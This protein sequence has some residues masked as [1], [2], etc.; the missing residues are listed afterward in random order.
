[1]ESLSSRQ[2]LAAD[3]GVAFPDVSGDGIL[4]PLDVLQVSNAV[5]QG[6]TATEQPRF[7]VNL[8]QVIDA[9]DVEATLAAL[10]AVLRERDLRNLETG[11]LPELDV[12]IMA[13][14]D[15]GDA[16]DPLMR[17]V[18]MLGIG[19][20]T[21]DASTSSPTERTGIRLDSTC[22][23]MELSIASLQMYLTSLQTETALLQDPIAIQQHQTLIVSV[24]NALAEAL[25]NYLAACG[26]D[27]DEF[28]DLLD[29]IDP[30]LTG[31]EPEFTDATGD[32]PSATP[33]PGTDL[34]TPTF[35]DPSGSPG[36]PSD[37]ESWVPSEDPETVSPG[38]DNQPDDIIPPGDSETDSPQNPSDPS[39][40]EPT[41]SGL[42]N[43]APPSEPESDIDEPTGT[44]PTDPAPPV[45]SDP[46]AT[47]PP[48]TPW[49]DDPSAWV[50]IPPGDHPNYDEPITAEIRIDFAYDP[51]AP[52]SYSDA[53]LVAGPDEDLI[54]TYQ[55]HIPFVVEV[56]TSVPA[57]GGDFYLVLYVSHDG[58]ER[59]FGN[60]PIPLHLYD[61]NDFYHVVIPSGVAREVGLR[62]ELYYT[63]TSLV[64]AVPTPQ[65]TASIAQQVA[66][67]NEDANPQKIAETQKKSKI[68][69][70]LSKAGSK[71]TSKLTQ[72]TKTFITDRAPS[73]AAETIVSSLYA[74]EDAIAILQQD[75]IAP[76]LA[77]Q[78]Y[79]ER[80]S[81]LTNELSSRIQPFFTSASKHIF[82]TPSPQADLRIG[83]ND[84]NAE[85]PRDIEQELDDAIA[86]GARSFEDFIDQNLKISLADPLSLFE[87]ATRSKLQDFIIHGD[88]ADLTTAL[89]SFNLR[90]LAIIKSISATYPLQSSDGTNIGEAFF[91]INDVSLEGFSSLKAGVKSQKWGPRQSWE[92]TF[93][94]EIREEDNKKRSNEIKMQLLY[95]R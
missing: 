67:S 13:A 93:H 77:K 5:S 57:H 40:P 52:L 11:G 83:D 95:S 12:A 61:G 1:M 79:E 85:A 65:S 55:T 50:P 73:K 66:E 62:A 41:D 80:S 8:D 28:T 53:N 51:D 45:D 39:I 29:T 60:A 68:R 18:G 4:S 63:Q 88:R 71:A 58:L 89:S 54:Y 82:N 75:G 70:F 74:K 46:P 81:A 16:N 30:A 48:Y 36:S 37:Q 2:L 78:I 87:Q 86:R 38:M 34:T 20:P 43:G 3:L 64:Q 26:G 19:S 94:Y 15:A 22:A 24:E 27:S 25:A 9:R 76:D 90:E 92:T 21:A 72:K 35:D 42:P 47:E 14:D 84:P 17:A 33:A 69:S 7:D 56:T 44:S 6:V 31:T 59:P 23:A 10:V 49:T 91:T 32:L